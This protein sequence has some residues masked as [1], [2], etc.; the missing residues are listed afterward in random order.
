MSNPIAD[1]LLAL[2]IRGIQFAIIFAVFFGIFA[3]ILQIFH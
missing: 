1:A 2:A 3:E